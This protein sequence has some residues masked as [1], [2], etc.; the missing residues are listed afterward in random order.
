MLDDSLKYLCLKT[1]E[2]LS[3]RSHFLSTYQFQ[4]F[5]FSLLIT[6]QSGVHTRGYWT[7]LDYRRISLRSNAERLGEGKKPPLSRLQDTS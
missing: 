6:C 1:T 5:S 3:Q 2:G 4:K 7:R